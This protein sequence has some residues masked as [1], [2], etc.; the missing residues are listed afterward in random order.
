MSFLRELEELGELRALA[1]LLGSSG[2]PCLKVQILSYNILS[3]VIFRI[4][5]DCSPIVVEDGT[6][7]SALAGARSEVAMEHAATVDVDDTTLIADSATKKLTQ[8][9]S[10]LETE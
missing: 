4:I 7:G 1:T 5:H 3:Q 2:Y 8:R 10:R 9:V 6:T